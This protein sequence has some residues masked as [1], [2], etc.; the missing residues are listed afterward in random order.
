MSTRDQCKQGTDFTSSR[1]L[2][3]CSLTHG[4]L[5]CIEADK[6]FLLLY[7]ELSRKPELPL[8]LVLEMFEITTDTSWKKHWSLF[9]HR[10]WY[11][12]F[13]NGFENMPSV[14]KKLTKLQSSMMLRC[15]LESS[16]WVWLCL[17]LKLLLE[18][19]LRF[20]LSGHLYHSPD[21]RGAY[22]SLL[23]PWHRP[24]NCLTKLASVY[25]S[26]RLLLPLGSTHFSAP[27]RTGPSLA[28]WWSGFL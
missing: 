4:R 16:W 10:S 12:G 22:L 27:R 15:I 21:Y 7:S 6:A 11:E 5:V 3:W 14:E 26:N 17:L 1:W 28:W 20:E 24:S 2:V 13:R 8:Y 25:R 23:L 18:F 9:T 19:Y